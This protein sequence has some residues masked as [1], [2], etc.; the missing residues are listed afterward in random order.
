MRAIGAALIGVQAQPCSLWPMA[1]QP[2][3]TKNI[4]IFIDPRRRGRNALPTHTSTHFNCWL[5]EKPLVAQATE[6]YY[7]RL[8]ST[9]LEWSR[10]ATGKLVDDCLQWQ[11]YNWQ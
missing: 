11:D 2:R 6:E 5:P 10:L 1:E 9:L 7:F 4:A 3:T 8:P